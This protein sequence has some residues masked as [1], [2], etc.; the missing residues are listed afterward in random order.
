M[1]C[2]RNYWGRTLC[3]PYDFLVI[4]CTKEFKSEKSYDEIKIICLDQNDFINNELN[5]E[6][7]LEALL[8]QKNNEKFIF[9]E[10]KYINQ[11]GFRYIHKCLKEFMKEDRIIERFLDFGDLIPYQIGKTNEEIESEDLIDCP[12]TNTEINDLVNCYQQYINYQKNN[13][14]KCANTNIMKTSS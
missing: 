1:I 6:R 5:P 13:N 14:Y 4:D 11:Y 7:K 9:L 10:S 8:M 12:L 2:G 3:V